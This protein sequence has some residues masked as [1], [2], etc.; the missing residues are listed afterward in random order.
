[1]LGNLPEELTPFVGRRR[2]LGEMRNLL[3]NTRVLT[4]IGTGGVGKTR[5]A[6]A[7]AADRQ[8]AFPDGV[9]FAALD[10]I[11]EE[12]LLVTRVS[13][14][15]GRWHDTREGDL[16]ESLAQSLRER[17]LLL[18]LDN[19]EHLIEGAAH[20]VDAIARACPKIRILA[21]SR[22]PLRAAGEV[23]YQVPP[24]WMPQLS[25]AGPEQD[26][27]ASDAVRFFVDRARAVLPEFELTPA[28]RD[29]VYE[30][31]RRLDRLPLAMELAAVRLRSLTVQQIGERYASHQTMLSWG[32]R[33]APFR[34]QTMR[35]S[36]QWSADL[37]T[38]QERRLWARLSV[39][40][41]TFDVEAVEAVCADDSSS[42]D[43]LDLLQS[44]VERSIIVREDHSPAV[45]YA[46][47]EVIRHFGRTLLDESGD[48]AVALRARHMT[49]FLDLVVRA[50]ADWNTDR[51]RHWLHVLP[52]EHK[53]IVRA[54]SAAAD[55]V[56]TVDAAATAVCGLRRYYWWASGWLA[57]GV[58]WVDR[59]SQLLTN[60]VLRGR[61]LLLGSQLAL[62]SGDSTSGTAWLH[63]GQMAAEESGDPLSRA[64]VEHVRGNAAMYGGQPR[65][66]VEHFRHAL[67]A[68]DADST[69]FRV[70]SLTALTLACAALGDVEGAEAA[71]SET[72][73]TLVP[74]ERF[75]RSYSLLYVGEAFC[76]RGLTDRALIAVRDALALKAD[77][78]D[79]FGVAWTFEV[80]A[81]I[82]CETRHYKRA[83]LLMGAASR[84]GKSMAIDV[85]T[86]ERL[87]LR[88]GF[89]DRLRSATGSAAFADDCL[90]GEQ[91]EL[92]AAIAVALGG[93]ATPEVPRTA[94]GLLTAREAE[95]ARLVAFGLTNKQIAS[96]LVIALRTV[97]AHVQNILTKL[98]FHSR[99]QIAAWV[100]ERSDR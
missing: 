27:D 87:Q 37:C 92:E 79:P 9:W 21:T 38:E 23:T 31:V 99:A 41:G 69:S 35:A 56:K 61:L 77:I 26:L 68:Y 74:A 66:A 24:L 97:D 43:V 62:I 64:L 11:E 75:Q 81:E 28:N 59:C 47:L 58:Y 85:P 32:S 13:G 76:R 72:L 44:L 70:D 18:I 39:F 60:P 20:L 17:H 57:E 4:L 84:V 98:G 1:M 34:Q 3:V 93:G 96:K 25:A 33:S 78:D 40:R 36:L 19:C 91:L 30:L 83:A 71:H 42:D 80:L 14:V 89:R 73:S 100:T 63:K 12:T 86:L 94:P 52:L 46:M 65:A 8:R 48:D 67:S 7:A 49:W 6:L 53:N 16:A 2:E 45:R 82:A 15:L 55:D 88:E 90:R 5:L 10:G 50:D 54:L 51:Q 95:I 22:M 29:G